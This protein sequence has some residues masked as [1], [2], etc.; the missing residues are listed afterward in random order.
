MSE[1]MLQQASLKRKKIG[2]LYALN[3]QTD[4]DIDNP[5][6]DESSHE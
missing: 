5:T 4:Q 6:N 3:D 1:G 2:E